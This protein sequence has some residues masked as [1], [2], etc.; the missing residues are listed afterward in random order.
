MH[1]DELTAPAGSRASDTAERG[2][3][4][5]CLARPSPRHHRS[6]FG[7]MGQARLWVGEAQ[8]EPLPNA[9]RAPTGVGRGGAV[10]HASTLTGAATPPET[11][12][13]ESGSAC[14]R[15]PPS[16]RPLPAP[17]KCLFKPTHCSAN[18]ITF[19]VKIDLLKQQQRRQ[20]KTAV[21]AKAQ[22]GAGSGRER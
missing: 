18:W 10:A 1:T 6:G 17:P 5:P 13:P 16:R 4:Q 7:R 15:R 2:L 11:T 8:G 21:T 3:E 12:V 19:H 14:Q 9:Q 20:I 22:R